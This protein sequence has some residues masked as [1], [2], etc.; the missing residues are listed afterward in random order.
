MS[1]MMP[2]EHEQ[3][4]REA[5]EAENDANLRLMDLEVK[6]LS[7]EVLLDIRDL[8]RELVV[9]MSEVRTNTETIAIWAERQPK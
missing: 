9:G 7:L 5:I 6:D 4:E 2:P 3:R 8:L 1:Y